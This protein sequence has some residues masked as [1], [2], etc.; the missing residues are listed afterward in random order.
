[1]VWSG[2]PAALVCVWCDSVVPAPSVV[3]FSNNRFILE[4]VR[5]IEMFQR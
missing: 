4:G 2:D 5:F 1:M 3:S